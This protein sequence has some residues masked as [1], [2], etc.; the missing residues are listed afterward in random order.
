MAFTHSNFKLKPTLHRQQHFS[1]RDISKKISRL[2]RKKLVIRLPKTESAVSEGL[3]LS[4]F[5]RSPVS[6]RRS[7]F[8]PELDMPSYDE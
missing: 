2:F 4:G 3:I 1:V 6:V 8:L 5:S 7:A